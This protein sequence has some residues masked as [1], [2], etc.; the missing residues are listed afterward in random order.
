[1]KKI[2][3]LI[4]FFFVPIAAQQKTTQVGIDLIKYFEGFRSRAYLCPANVLTIGYGSTGSHVSRGMIITKYEAERLLI[5]DLKRFEN[6][7]DRIIERQLKWH[8]FDALVSF[9]F[10]LGFR[11]KDEFLSAINI[12]NTK[13]V[14]YKLKQY[15]RARV[16][17]ILLVLPGLVKRREAESF[18]Y[19]NPKINIF[20]EFL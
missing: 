2:L 4:L 18:V 14:V 5:K 12:G 7:V 10:N 17:G 13:M 9:S 16:N 15:N 8:E 1:M 6:Y 20:K 19:S 11:I 3:L